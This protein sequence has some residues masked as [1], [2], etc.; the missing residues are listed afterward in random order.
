MSRPFN[1]SAGPAVLPEEVLRTAASEMLDWHGSGM[2]VMEMSHR[3]REFISIYEAAERDLRELLAV[4]QEFKILFMQGGGLAENA[5][6]PLNLSRGAMDFVITGAWSEKSQQEAGRFKMA[7]ATCTFAATR[8]SMA[9]SSSSCPI[10]R[11]WAVTRPWWSIFLR[12]YV[13]ARLIGR[14]W[15]WPLAGPRKTWVRRASH[16]WWCAKTCWATRCPSAHRPSITSWW[17][18][19]G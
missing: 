10:S 18:T 7:A 5:I 11:P 3:G 17:P 1:F 14:A 8:P 12:M 9:W 13:R 4:P 16:W 6:V 15:V 2:S 19:Q